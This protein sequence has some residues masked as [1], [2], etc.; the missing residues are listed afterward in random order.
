MWPNN[1][2]K[3]ALNAETADR[4]IKKTKIRAEINNKI[5]KFN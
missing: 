2:L 3:I 1:I 5:S 4:I